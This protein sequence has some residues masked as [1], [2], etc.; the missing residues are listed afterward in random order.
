MQVYARDMSRIFKW[1]WAKPA[2]PW[3]WSRS[4]RGPEPPV[5][6]SEYH[7]RDG[8]PAL[9]PVTTWGYTSCPLELPKHP[10][11][12]NATSTWSTKGL[13]LERTQICQHLPLHKAWKVS[14]TP[15]TQITKSMDISL[16]TTVAADGGCKARIKWVG[17]GHVSGRL[18]SKYTCRES[19][20]GAWLASSSSRSVGKADMWRDKILTQSKDQGSWKKELI[21]VLCGREGAQNKESSSRSNQE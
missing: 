7:P 8:V 1:T 12:D 3:G 21:L 14:A 18:W 13:P 10:A 16:T 5:T 9:Q 4:P 6:P 2:R 17:M 20:Q 15:T 11:N 19:R